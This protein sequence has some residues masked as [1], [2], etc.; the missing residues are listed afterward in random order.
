M[1]HLSFSQILGQDWAVRFLKQVILMEK[2]PHGYLFVGIPG[3]GKTTTAVALTQAINCLEPV[4]GEGC[5]RC[6]A[7]KWLRSGN[8]G[9][10]VIIHPEGQSIKIEKIRDLE[11]VLG[12]KPQYGRYRVTVVR[13]AELMTEEASNAFLK[14]LEEPPP[15][16]IL[17]L[18][19]SDPSKL[20]PTI[21]SRC[22]KVNFRPIPVGLIK[23]WLAE[24]KGVDEEKALLLAKLSEGSLGRALRMWEED[25]LGRRRRYLSEFQG[26]PTLSDEEVLRLALA[27]R[28]RGKKDQGP[29]PERG[30]A[31]I[32][33]ALSL[34]KTWTRDALL[35]NTEGPEGLLMNADFREELKKTFGGSRIDALMEAFRLLDQAEKDLRRFRNLDLLMENLLLALKGCMGKR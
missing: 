32:A 13:Q 31:E 33:E 18:N 19:A 6:R 16:N 27:M 9:D 2:I 3:V 30:S 12:Y 1:E 21:V 4:S 7:C 35:L 10:L 14:T 8:I 22:Q 28:G 34:W 17:I 20:L 29:G 25:Y 24:R 5:G 11:R 26:L 15:G 23:E